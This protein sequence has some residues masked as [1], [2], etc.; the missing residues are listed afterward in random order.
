MPWMTASR[1]LGSLR[2]GTSETTVVRDG[3]MVMRPREVAPRPRYWLIVIAS[4]GRGLV[5]CGAKEKRE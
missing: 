5:T 1:S 2:Y 3:V 4:G